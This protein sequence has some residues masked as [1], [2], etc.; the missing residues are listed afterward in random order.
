MMYAL[1]NAELAEILGLTDLR[2]GDKKSGYMVTVGDLAAYG[3]QRAV[4]EG[5][6]LMTCKEAQS[7]VYN[8]KNKQI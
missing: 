2:T 6:K 1:I 8:F 4:D 5:A 7:W 3:A